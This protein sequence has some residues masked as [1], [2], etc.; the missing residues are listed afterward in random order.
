MRDTNID[1]PCEDH[2]KVLNISLREEN[3]RKETGIKSEK[4]VF[5]VSELM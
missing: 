4:K 2:T 5:S 3:R 1:T